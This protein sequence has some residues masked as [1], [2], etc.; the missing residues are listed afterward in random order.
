[1]LS[2]QLSVYLD[3]SGF[4]FRDRL[5]G[6]ACVPTRT[7]SIPRSAH[8]IGPSR[9][10]A[11]ARGW[12][13][14]RRRSPD[15][16]GPPVDLVWLLPAV[17]EAVVV[18]DLVE[19]RGDVAKLV[20]DALDCGAHVRPIT[21]SPDISQKAGASESLLW[22]SCCVATTFGTSGRNSDADRV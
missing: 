6:L 14:C 18:F 2:E 17:P 22:E 12:R 16:R 13:R 15:R 7:R 8:S 1:M 3:R 20:P 10:A 11:W 9:P 21:V 5:D 19:G 4:L